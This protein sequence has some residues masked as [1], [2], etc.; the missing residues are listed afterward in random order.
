M[1]MASA[2]VPATNSK[3]K[4]V[5]E[6]CSHADV[7]SESLLSVRPAKIDGQ[8]VALVRGATSAMVKGTSVVV[9]PS[10][11]DGADGRPF[12]EI[13]PPGRIGSPTGDWGRTIGRSLAWLTKRRRLMS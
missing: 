2:N 5:V 10:S 12:R 1:E 11:H 4:A 7:R 6:P 9:E 8:K 13:A 3:G